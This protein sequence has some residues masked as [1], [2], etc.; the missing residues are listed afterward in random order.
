MSTLLNSL[1]NIVEFVLALGVLIFLHEFGHYLFSKLFKIQVEEFGFG[2]PPR[3]VRLFNIGETEFTLNWIPFGAFVRP[4]GEND[5]SVPGGMASATPLQRLLI[6]LGGPLMNV[7][8]GLVLFSLVYSLAGAPDLSKVEVVSVNA[9]SPAQTAGLQ[10]GDLITSVAG[11]AVTGSQQLS[12]TIH[13]NLDQLIEITYQRND[14]SY[15]TSVVPRSNPPEGEGAIGIVM[16]NPVQPV[17]WF[18]ALPLATRDTY[19]QALLLV[20][21]PIKLIRGEVPADQARFVGPKGMYDIYQVVRSEDQQEEAA[22][23]N[24]APIRTLS[25]LATI[26]IALGITNLLPI[27]ALDGGRILFVLP[28]LILRKRVPAQYENM[29]HLIGFAALLLLMVIIT[30]QDFINPIQLR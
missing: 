7:V 25:L 21:T 19:E 16:T 4:K 28:E 15:S 11:V 2:F 3:M 30:A 5:P 14:Q 6:L 1:V 10:A 13:A 26:S 29:V 12:D 17:N 23:P 27:P 20:E 8:T 9:S 18:S 24:T 22:M